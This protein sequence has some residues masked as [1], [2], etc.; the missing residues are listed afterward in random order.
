MADDEVDPGFAVKETYTTDENGMINLERLQ[1]GTYCVQETATIDGYILNDTVYEFTI[2]ED[3]QIDG[4]DA[5]TLTIENDKE[6]NPQL[7]T[8][9]IDLESG[10]HEAIAKEDITIRDTVDYTDVAPGTY[11]LVG[12]LMDQSTGEPLLVDGEQVTAEKEV[13]ITEENGT[14][15]MDFTFDASELG[16]T[17]T[18]VFEYLYPGDQD[19]HEDTPYASHEDINDEDQTVSFKVG[20][21]TPSL[22]NQ[23]GSGMN[24]PQTGDNT[25]LYYVLGM[26]CIAVGAGTVTYVIRKKKK[27]NENEK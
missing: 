12:I 21:L 17:S 9:A 24:A 8:T 20:T 2:S 16:G 7:H 25:T 15:T 10:T 19:N 4:Q 1:P 27:V 11:T 23:N 22:P 6:R 14:L 18:V 13:Q 3:G 5:Y 26:M